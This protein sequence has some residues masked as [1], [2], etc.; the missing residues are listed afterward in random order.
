MECCAAGGICE[1]CLYG[2]EANIVYGLPEAYGKLR[3]YCEG[4]NI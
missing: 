1:C 2:R 4:N 3:T